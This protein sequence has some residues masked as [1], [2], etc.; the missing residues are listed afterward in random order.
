[1]ATWTWRVCL[2]DGLEHLYPTHPT[3]AVIQALCG[4][5]DLAHKISH[6]RIGAR[7][8]YLCQATE[9]RPA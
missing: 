4:R 6:D 5:E 2:D 7:R 8:C 9:S 3:S 1:M